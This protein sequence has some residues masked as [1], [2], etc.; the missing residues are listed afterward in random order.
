M[1]R[2]RISRVEFYDSFLFDI[3]LTS[4]ASPE[5]LAPDMFHETY[6]DELAMM[7]PQ[8][9]L[10]VLSEEAKNVNP[11]GERISTEEYWA[12]LKAATNKLSESNAL[13]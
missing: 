7:P 8:I 3:D 10:E 1:T 12:M 13:D 6:V 4:I 5:N 2:A 9:V 11:D